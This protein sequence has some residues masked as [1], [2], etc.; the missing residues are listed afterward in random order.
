MECYLHVTKVCPTPKI[1]CMECHL[2][3]KEY[4]LDEDKTLPREPYTKLMSATLFCR[5][6]GDR[7]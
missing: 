2:F 7:K 5:R 1:D 3:L 4:E 6:T